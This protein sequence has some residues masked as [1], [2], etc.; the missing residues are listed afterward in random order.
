MACVGKY[1]IRATV[2]GVKITD[3]GTA[4]FG[5]NDLCHINL[6]SGNEKRDHGTRAEQKPVQAQMQ[7]TYL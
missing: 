7:V 1:D 5:N 3:A 2:H 6:V 4:K